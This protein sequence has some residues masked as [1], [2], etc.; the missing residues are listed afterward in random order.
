MSKVCGAHWAYSEVAVQK[1][2]HVVT[3]NYKNPLTTVNIMQKY[4]IISGAW[5]SIVV[6]ALRY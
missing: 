4:T 1:I 3:Q 5:G 2:S 6:K